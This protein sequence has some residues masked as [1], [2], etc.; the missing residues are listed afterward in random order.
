MGLRQLE[1]LRHVAALL[2]RRGYDTRDVRLACY[3]SV[4][5][6]PDLKAA[7]GRGEVMLVTPDSLYA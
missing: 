6:D 4:G 1:R 2:S 3:S 7:A 5:F